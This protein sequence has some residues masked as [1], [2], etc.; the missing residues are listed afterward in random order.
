MEDGRIEYK[1]EVTDTLEKEVV[2][3]LNTSGGEIHIG[4]NDNK[5]IYGIA[6]PDLV[7]RQIVDRLKNNISPNILGLFDIVLEKEGPKY[8]VRII[9]SA[10]S[11]RPYYITRYGRTPK[12]CYIRVGSTCQMMNQEMIDSMY[13]NRVRPNLS[14]IPSPRQDLTFRDLQIY[15]SDRDIPFNRSWERNLEFLTPDDK[16]NY[17][18]YLMADSNGMSFRVAKYRGTDKT[19]LISNDEYGYCCLIKAT[20]AILERLKIEN[21]THAKVTSKTRIEKNL[22]DSVALREAIINAIVHNDFTREIPPV[23]EIFKDRIV[24]TSYG[25]LIPGQ[26]QEDFFSCNSMPRNRELMRVFKDVGLVEQLGSG[27][28]RILK[29]YPKDIFDISEH[30]IKVVFPFAEIENV[31]N[32]AIGDEN[33]NDNGDENGNENNDVIKTLNILRQKPDITAKALSE[34]MGISSRKVSRIIKNLK[35]SGKITRVG[36]DR[37]GYWQINE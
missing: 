19:D 33:G 32:I 7:Q 28:S 2:A 21:V 22:V 15:Y 35:E 18:A 36:S 26:S 9:V 11:E 30:F 12:D 6:D 8:Y 23:F 5:T 14:I 10:G 34:L 16:Y 29:V 1:R 20:H 17:I 24:M 4:V 37:K 13:K 25:G 31:S 3:F 27:M